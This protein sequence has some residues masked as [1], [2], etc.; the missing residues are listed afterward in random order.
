MRGQD[1]GHV[2]HWSFSANKGRAAEL[3]SASRH[4]SPSTPHLV[5]QTHWHLLQHY[6][7]PQN[8]ATKETAIVLAD[9]SAAASA[10]LAADRSRLS[11][12]PAFGNSRT[13][14]SRP[15]LAQTI[16]KPGKTEAGRRESPLPVTEAKSRPHRACRWEV[17]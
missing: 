15:A 6:E 16:T 2:A 10:V 1:R 3:T 8:A 4:L 14:L 7:P 17:R 5:R 13:S 12:W 9:A 11:S